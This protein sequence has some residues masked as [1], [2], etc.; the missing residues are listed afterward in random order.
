MKRIPCYL[1][2]I[3]IALM[4]CVSN[5]KINAAV[6]QASTVKELYSLLTHGKDPVSKVDLASD[7]T[8]RLTANISINQDDDINDFVI[9]AEV[10]RTLDLNGYTLTK[11]SNESVGLVCL[12]YLSNK[13]VINII[14]SRTG[15]K[16]VCDRKISDNGNYLCSVFCNVPGWT[17]YNIGA[18]TVNLYG[19]SI[20]TTFNGS[21]S[22]HC[23]VIVGQFGPYEY[24]SQQA[25]EK[26]TDYTVGH[27]FTLNMY[28]GTISDY[29][30]TLNGKELMHGTTWYNIY[31]TRPIYFDLNVYD[32]T[33]GSTNTLSSHIGLYYGWSDIKPQ[34]KFRNALI[35]GLSFRDQE[36]HDGFFNNLDP[37]IK[38]YINKVETPVS[39]CL[40]AANDAYARSMVELRY[41]PDITVA[42]VKVTKDNCNDLLNGNCK[43]WFDYATNT[44]HL[45]KRYDSE[46]YYIPGWIE[47]KDFNLCIQVDGGK[48]WD[49]V[50][51][52]G[53][54]GDLHITTSNYS[55]T[56]EDAPLVL[57]DGMFDPG[58]NI[59]DNNQL[60]VSNRLNLKVNNNTDRHTSAVKCHDM[61][62]NN[63]WFYAMG[64]KPVVD[65][66]Y[67]S[68]VNA[69]IKTGSFKNH[70]II[71]VDP[72]ITKYY[73]FIRTN[74]KEWGSISGAGDGIYEEGTKLTVT[75]T[76]NPGYYFDRWY[77]D[78]FTDA[79]RT[80]TVTEDATYTALFFPEEV[81][82]YYD[83]RVVSADETMGTVSG[84]GLQLEKGQTVKI[85]A[86]PKT[87]Y[88]FLYWTTANGQVQGRISEWT[89]TADETLTAHFR[90]QPP[91]D[92]YML[93]VCGTQVTGSNSA[94]I[95]GDGVWNY[96]DATRTLTVMK[97]ATYNISNDGFI[98]DLV[99]S[100]PLTVNLSNH[101]IS[102][103]CTTTD[104]VLRNAIVSHKGITF[105]GSTWH[106]L[107][108]TAQNMYAANLSDV[109]TVTGHMDLS[110]N[111]KNTTDWGKSNIDKALLLSS[112]TPALVVDGANLYV[113]AGQGASDQYNYKVSNKTDQSTVL[114]LNNASVTGGSIS[115]FYISV[116]DDSPQY[117]IN[118]IT[119]SL[120][121]L[122]LTSVFGL[123]FY[124]GT[125]FDLR[126]YPTAGYKFVRWSDGNTDNP[127]LMIMPAHDVY[128]D[129]IVEID[130]SLT[131]T[132]AIINANATEGQGSI[133]DFTS[134]WYAEGTELTITAVPTAGYEFVQWSDG[135]TKNPY[136]LIVEDGKNISVTAMFKE[137]TTG[138]NSID[139]QTLPA[140]HKIL[141]DGII[142]IE[143]N[144]K[145]YNLLGNETQL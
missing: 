93:Y 29:N 44:L 39:T 55:L 83:I 105:T 119:P 139:A 69:H 97:D 61:W 112:K 46:K 134:G 8:I 113:S 34:S 91:A 128:L 72:D 42:K 53:E 107:T 71:K 65:C 40:S 114:G 138:I 121:S 110:L 117:E 124:E 76:P 84:G 133:A 100:G 131:Q 62:V 145:T 99:T 4:L 85:S 7:D 33:F 11:T 51:I 48:I 94:D 35:Y 137:G 136:F 141:R 14:N 32:G 78:G 104:N 130:N 74:G 129:P 111:H 26:V 103:T 92:A 60:V 47:Y 73:I 41:E 95:L 38:I 59:G 108:V 28:G 98:E 18:S 96:D 127:R 49:L 64:T 12:F 115:H 123:S 80:I 2:L 75:A 24:Y 67:G 79:T 82:N 116:N 63:S 1:S 20:Q 13:T 86:T 19:G 50:C 10:E 54:N 68:V 122:C 70:D 58:I 9:P 143:R 45:D 89:V 57:V 77:E 135:K 5:I 22:S 30:N 17:I 140:A 15:G 106:G 36:S 90:K 21:A 25:G 109:L 6:Y 142:Y 101:N 88:E 52:N 144:G 118:Y 16:I 120:A 132:G 31:F 23:S 66:A 43:V 56:E 81:V 102:A 37:N 126:A 125:Y 3:L 27:Y 87:G